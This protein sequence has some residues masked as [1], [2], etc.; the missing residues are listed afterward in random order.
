MGFEIFWQIVGTSHCFQIVPQL[1][2]QFLMRPFLYVYPIV[3]QVGGK[4]HFLN[5]IADRISCSS[6][7]LYVTTPQHQA[8]LVVG[9]CLT[10]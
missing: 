7:Y 2:G 10:E 6:R 9:L 1:G 3:H 5:Y 4:I 8:V